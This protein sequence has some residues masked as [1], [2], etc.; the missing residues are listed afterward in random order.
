[1]FLVLLSGERKGAGR[2]FCNRISIPSTHFPGIHRAYKDWW[3]MREREREYCLR[4]G[5]Y[6]LNLFV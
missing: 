3:N 1:M 5:N 6:R 2:W 4:A